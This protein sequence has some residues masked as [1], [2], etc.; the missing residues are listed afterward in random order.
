[1]S[2]PRIS[3]KELNKLKQ[4]PT[5]I[6][7]DCLNRMNTM[8]ATI[9]PLFEPVKIV[10]QAITVQGMVGCNIASHKAI[11]IAKRGDIVVFDA[12]GYL[13]T[14]VWGGVQTI[15][16][17]KRGIQGVVIDG[18]IRDKNEIKKLRLPV[19]CKGVTPAGPHK[20]W[21]DN[22]NV[23]ISC[24]GCSVSP[25]DV[26]VGDEDG[27][28]VIPLKQVKSVIKYSIETAKKEKEWIKKI[29]KGVPTTKILG[30][31]KKIK[32]F[33]IKINK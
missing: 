12:R 29:K 31:D 18:S 26:I 6:I 8:H 21:S 1:M 28:C 15:A 19:F 27:V 13:D 7:S 24:G 10:G 11:Y 25:G 33:K 9:K 3:Q 2:I 4:I 30:L 20:G 32:E 17:K 16:A 23:P 22:I 5:T 14:A